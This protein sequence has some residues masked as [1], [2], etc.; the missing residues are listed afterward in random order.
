[1]KI[2]ASRICLFLTH[3][4]HISEAGDG[5]EGGRLRADLA[6]VASRALLRQL[7][8]LDLTRVRVVVVHDHA[9]TN[10]VRDRLL[11]AWKISG[12]KIIKSSISSETYTT[13]R[14]ADDLSVT[15]TLTLNCIYVVSSSI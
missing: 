9:G 13:K 8:Q 4:L 1:M 12:N 6:P 10:V 2:K 7:R 5:R 14:C 11:P 3:N 15:L